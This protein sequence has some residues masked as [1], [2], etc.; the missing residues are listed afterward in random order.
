MTYLSDY[1]V[2]L[3]D[4]VYNLKEFSK[5]HPGGSMILNIFGGKDATIHY[6][7]LHNHDKIR[8]ILDKYKLRNFV[9]ATNM[10]DI[11]TSNFKE[12]K[13]KVKNAI[14]YPYANLEWYIKAVCIL[15]ICIYLEYSN[16]QYGFTLIKS[17]LQGYM[18]AMIGLCIQHDANHGAISPNG[19]VN[20]LWGYT[21][22]FI[23][24]SALLWKH[25]HVLLHHAYT[26]TIDNDPDFSIE[27]IR[28]HRYMKILPFHQ[29]QSTYIW[30]LL[31]LLPF[32]WHFK[33][34]YDLLS[35][36][37]C[38][39]KIS[40]MAKSEMFFSLLLRFLFILR[41]YIIPFYFY[42][43]IN[44]IFYMTIT[45]LTGGLYLGV[46]FIISHIFEGVKYHHIENKNKIDW[47][48]LQIETS[49][50]VGGRLLG[51]FHGGLNYQI[52][53][54]LFPRI[55]H[56]HYHKIQPIIMDWCKKN[57]I[58][59]NYFPNIITNIKSCFKYIDEMGNYY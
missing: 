44:T 38:D 10:Y 32:S 50:S 16:I 42:P 56:V 28:L 25:H 40:K 13:N 5:V 15:S 2:V 26:N 19:W 47:C 39:V 57:N 53:H 18:M 46:N 30:F 9:N 51:F 37:H 12:L 55:C 45:L 48:I 4:N 17:I 58:K 6:Y 35:M 49:S 3:E 11:N 33:E 22:D 34:I 27:I 41:F 36:T 20:L 43:S 14:I 29:W 24:G 8:P 52:E 1:E 54:H 7:M 23:G 21:Q 59:Y 31:P